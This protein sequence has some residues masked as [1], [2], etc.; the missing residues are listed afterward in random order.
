VKECNQQSAALVTCADIVSCLN[1]LWHK[2]IKLT[3][4]FHS[5]SRNLH[6]TQLKQKGYTRFFVIWTSTAGTILLESVLVFI[7]KLVMLLLMMAT[8]TMKISFHLTYILK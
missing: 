5:A 7:A 1:E 4:V 8:K 2:L 6:P 3:T